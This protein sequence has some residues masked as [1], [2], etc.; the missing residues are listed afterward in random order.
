MCAFPVLIVSVLRQTVSPMPRK[1][2][3]H[4]LTTPPLTSFLI[5][6]VKDFSGCCAGDEE[7]TV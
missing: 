1:P 7:F 4:P 3:S 2:A 5:I 6:I